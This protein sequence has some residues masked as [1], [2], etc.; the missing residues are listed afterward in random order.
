MFYFISEYPKIHPFVVGIWCG[1]SKPN[2]NEYLQPFV[3]EMK[4]L[5]ADKFVVNEHQIQIKFGLIISDTPAR[6]ML[7]G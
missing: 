3:T 5:M 2:V 7:K 6:A 1:I 4:L